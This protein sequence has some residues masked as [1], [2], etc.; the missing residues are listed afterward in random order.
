M[1]DYSKLAADTTIAADNE[2]PARRAGRTAEPNPFTDLV[3]AAAKD[4]KRRDLPGRF[5]LVPYEGKKSACEAYSVIGKLKAAARAA[6]VDITVR[7]LDPTSE[8]T[9]WTFKASK[10]T[11]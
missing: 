9:G 1:I 11:R 6:G 3:T 7:K 8:D 10:A 2:F 5:S 4:G